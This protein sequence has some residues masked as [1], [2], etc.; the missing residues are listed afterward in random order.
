MTAMFA[1]VAA[2]T[3]PDYLK[4]PFLLILLGCS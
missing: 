3:L 2:G 1:S 4:S